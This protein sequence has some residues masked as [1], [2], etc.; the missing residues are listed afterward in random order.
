[1]RSDPRER[2]IGVRAARTRGSLANLDGMQERCQ[3][4]RGAGWNVG[5]GHVWTAIRVHRDEMSE[6][7]RRER[8]SRTGPVST[9]MLAT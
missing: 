4:W 9:V 5:D 7:P 1:M 8:F 2:R 6:L 3:K